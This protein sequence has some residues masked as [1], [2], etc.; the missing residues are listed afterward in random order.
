M[1]R[2]A[3]TEV[4]EALNTKR[5]EQMK[6]KFQP[7][8]SAFLVAILVMQSLAQLFPVFQTVRAETER[9]LRV[10]LE[11]DTI[12]P[13]LSLWMWGDVVTESHELGNWPNGSP[14]VE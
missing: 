3:F 5:R 8:F 10:H 7:L 12:N 2:R 1:V 6:Q 13:G 4:L 11:T 9:S 14:F